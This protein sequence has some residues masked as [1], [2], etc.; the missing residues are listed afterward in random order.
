MI[1][2]L[3]TIISVEL[4]KLLLYGMLITTLVKAV[5]SICEILQGGAGENGSSIAVCCVT[6]V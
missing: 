4:R 5:S 3:D 6:I 1:L 2:T